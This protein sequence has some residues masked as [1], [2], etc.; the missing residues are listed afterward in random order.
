MPLDRRHDRE[1]F[2][3]GVEALD[4]Y[5]R[6][7]ASQDSRRNVATVFVAEEQGTGT[8]HGFYTLS[9]AAVLL[10]RLPDA[11]QRKLPRYPTVPAVRLGRL[12]VALDAR[13]TGL[14]A[15]LLMDAM[16]RS[17]GSEIA[18]AAL[19]VDAKDDTARS[20][21]AKHGFRSLLDDPNHLFLTRKTIE[22][23][24]GGG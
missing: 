4:H 24:L 7:Q 13:G 11:L 1:A 10:D 14:G 2:R 17:L 15:H 22:P 5:F 3:C 16:A 19:L 23:L 9:M 8:V 21:Y 6:Q 18:W 20:F 12:A